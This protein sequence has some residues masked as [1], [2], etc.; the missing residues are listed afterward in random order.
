MALTLCPNCRL[1]VNTSLVSCPLC[2]ASLASSSPTRHVPV[3]AAA[4][5]ILASHQGWIQI[6]DG[7]RS[8]WVYGRYIE[9]Y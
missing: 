9:P 7:S 4:V 1:P 5:A 6:S 3:A 8:G 2:T